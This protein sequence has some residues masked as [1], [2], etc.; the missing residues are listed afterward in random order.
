MDTEKAA[1][2]A[3]ETA[4]LGLPESPGTLDNLKRHFITGLKL[5]TL[6]YI[7]VVT[8]PGSYR[9]I[10]PGLDNGWRYGINF[11]S[12]A[13]THFKYGRDVNFTYGPL[14]YLLDPLNIGT[15]LVQ[16]LL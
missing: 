12:A 14:G 5:A 11:A 15:N 10:G 3:E 13:H 8:F 6:V 7:L 16:A 1:V 4:P 9:S 2:A